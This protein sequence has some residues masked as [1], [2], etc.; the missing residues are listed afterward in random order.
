[1]LCVGLRPKWENHHLQDL[2]DS[3]GQE[4]V[5]QVPSPAQFRG[6]LL[7]LG[8]V[9]FPMGDLTLGQSPGYSLMGLEFLA[10]PTHCLYL[11]TR[12]GLMTPASL[13]HSPP[14]PSDIPCRGNQTGSSYLFCSTT[15]TEQG[16]LW[17]SLMLDW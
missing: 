5:S 17:V 16:P 12:F 2:Q 14:P 1:M 10:C 8:P 9:S 13:L 3:Y 7:H 6:H 11:Q 4:W 15:Y